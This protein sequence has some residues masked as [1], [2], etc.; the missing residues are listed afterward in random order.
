MFARDYARNR[1]TAKKLDCGGV[2]AIT[3]FSVTLLCCSLHASQCTLEF[4]EL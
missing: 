3:T 2:W 1:L 4:K